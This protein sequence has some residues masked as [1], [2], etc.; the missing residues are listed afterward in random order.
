M[1]L[2]RRAFGMPGADRGRLSAH[3]KRLISIYEVSLIVPRN[4][5][6]GDCDQFY[7]ESLDMVKSQPRP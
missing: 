7:C 2:H 4:A 1:N 6:D 5:V 3:P